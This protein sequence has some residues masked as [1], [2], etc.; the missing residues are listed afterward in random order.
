MAIGD[1]PKYDF[2]S[3][4]IYAALVFIGLISIYSAAPVTQYTSIFDINQVYGKQLLFIGVCT[5]FIII[6]LAVE[7]KF[8][9][10]FAGLIYVISLISLAGLYVLGKEVNGAVSWYP[11]GSFTFQPSEFA[12][13]ATALAVAKFLSQLDVSLKNV[14]DFM[15]VAG[16]IALPALLIIPQ[17]DPGSALI[18]AA[19]FFALHREG[20]SPWYLSLGVIAL[21]LFLGA[22]V[23]HIGWIILI[24][25]SVIVF[26]YLLSRKQKHKKRLPKPRVYLYVIAALT[27]I[28]YTFSTSYIFNNVLEDRHRNRIDIVL[29]RVQ[30]DAGIGYNINQ[31]MIAIGNG[32][33][34]GKPLEEATQTRGGYVPEQHTDFIFSAIGEVSG[35]LGTSITILLFI[36]LIYRVII[37]AERQRNQFARIYGYGVAG[38]FFLHFFVNV[39]MVIGLLPTVGIPLP[40]MSY[41]GSGL[42]GF[43][44]LLFIFIKL[45]AHRM[46][47]EH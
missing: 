36:F 33:I 22:L 6:I 16:I 4:L 27:C 9:E 25:L 19:F 46:S 24:I 32:G 31:S 1:K 26:M 44:I 21:A 13:F 47:Y 34:I 3:I 45:D 40:F 17:P 5:I 37:M 42:M 2:I 12:K 10:R 15:I 8:Y 38:I 30:D 18:Y 29:G 28:A 23:I 35:L 39:G 14:R 43:T 20:L 7:V 11:I 41:G